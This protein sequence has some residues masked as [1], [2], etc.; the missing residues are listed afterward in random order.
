MVLQA[1]GGVVPRRIR[2]LRLEDPPRELVR[3]SGIVGPTEPDVV[4]VGG[5]LV[6]R[7][8]LGHHPELSPPELYVVIDLV[9]PSARGATPEPS[10]DTIRIAVRQR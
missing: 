8:R 4:S 10:G 2:H 9:S 5:A 6:S 7:I 3:I 1:D